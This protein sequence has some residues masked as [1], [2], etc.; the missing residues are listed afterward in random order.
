VS[1]FHRPRS[2]RTRLALWYGL[3]VGLALVAYAGVVYAF[4]RASLLEQLDARLHEDYEAVEHAFERTSD[5]GLR[6]TAERHDPD[7]VSVETPW[8]EVSRADVVLLRRP[9][10]RGPAAGPFRTRDYVH[11]LDAEEFSIRVGRSESA[12]RHE[13]RELLWI[14]GAG[15]LPAVVLAFLGGRVLARRALA[16]V[17]AMTERASTITA[18]RL[19]DRLPV[20]NPHDEMGRLA[21]VFNEMFARLERSFDQLRRFTADASHELRTPLTAIR[22]VGE[23]GLREHRDE[24]GYREVVGS[25]L[26]E[27]DRLTQLVD[28]LLTLSRGDAGGLKLERRTVDLV[29]LV[30][31][32]ASHLAVLAEEKGQELTL[33]GVAQASADVDPLVVRQAVTNVV[34]NAI[35]YGPE[36]STVTIS[37]SEEGS[38]TTIGVTDQGPGISPEHRDRVFERFYRADPA[39]SRG[40]VGLGLAIAKAAVEAHGGRIELDVGDRGGC[41][42]RLVLPRRTPG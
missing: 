32:V 21:T 20:E 6:W 36:R 41:T 37:V 16:P 38:E 1:A 11:R 2:V 24:A 10:E 13:L 23:V 28:G 4:F 30:R 31:E 39:R 42:F 14:F 27:A 29:A 22:S 9:A 33:N 26:E 40:G 19:T 25:M 34:D 15:L 12:V 7:A 8:A 18:D 35:K 3:A 17:D 5:G